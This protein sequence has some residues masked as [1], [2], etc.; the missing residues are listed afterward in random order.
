MRQS[1]GLFHG[2]KVRPF[3]SLRHP[4]MFIWMCAG[5]LLAGAAWWW[6]R[7]PSA[8]DPS[9]SPLARR[10]LAE[11]PGHFHLARSP[12]VEVYAMAPELAGAMLDEANFALVRSAGHLGVALPAR[13]VRVILIPGDTLW[14]QL[15]RE[16]GFRPDSMALNWRDEVFLKEGGDQGARPDRLTHELVHFVLREA[17]GDRV[18]LW[19]DEGLA[20]RVGLKVSRAYRAQRGR[21]VTGEWPG[22]PADSVESLRVL[23]S[24]TTLPDDPAAA[25]AFYRAAEELVAV[26]EDRVGAAKFPGYVADVIAGADWR[27]ALDARLNGTS[28]RSVD[29]EDVVRR[30][31]AAPRKL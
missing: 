11:A 6:W 10:A 28:L 9:L 12:A 23:T 19:L 24:R 29:V 5:L 30:Q 20:G 8:G 15:G 25:R 7:A 16:R 13:P 22:I 17:Y 4:L 21:R 14:A 27:A 31:V 26:I 1:S 18:P 2:V 3:H